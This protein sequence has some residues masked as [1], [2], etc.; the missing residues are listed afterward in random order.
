MLSGQLWGMRISNP[1][2]LAA[3]FDKNGEAIDGPVVFVFS[4]SF[5]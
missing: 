1:L 3:G 4:T 5:C 2:G